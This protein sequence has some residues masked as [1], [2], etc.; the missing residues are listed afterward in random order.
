MSS[1]K[2]VN[3]EI[4]LTKHVKVYL[5]LAHNIFLI[6]H[7]SIMYKNLKMWTRNYVISLHFD[8]YTKFLEIYYIV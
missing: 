2:I 7:E 5:L 4:L 3:T 8:L 6:N 1:V